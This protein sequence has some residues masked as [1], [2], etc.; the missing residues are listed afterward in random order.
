[1]QELGEA[2][3]AAIELL[4]KLN[5]DTDEQ[6]KVISD[7]FKGICKAYNNFYY[8]DTMPI[9]NN[10]YLTISSSEGLIYIRK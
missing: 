2:A 1:M 10:K 9:G 6:L 4:Q 5:Q 7:M 8:E 3:L